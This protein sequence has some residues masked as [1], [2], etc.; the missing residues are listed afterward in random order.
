MLISQKFWSFYFLPTRSNFGQHI[1]KASCFDNGQ[2][3]NFGR[4]PTS[5]LI[6]LVGTGSAS[7]IPRR[8]G[9][10]WILISIISRVDTAMPGLVY[11]RAIRSW[12]ESWCLKD[13]SNHVLSPSSVCGWLKKWWWCEELFIELV[14]LVGSISYLN[15][16]V[17]VWQSS[18]SG[19]DRCVRAIPG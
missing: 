1:P 5:I 19:R 13:S 3:P 14:E 17:E 15:I 11:P 2:V 6:C 9:A 18:P 16:T 12:R 7:I 4:H 10:F 8:W